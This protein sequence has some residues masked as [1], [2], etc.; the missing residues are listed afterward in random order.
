MNASRRTHAGPQ[1]RGSATI[2]S[3]ARDERDPERERVL[4]QRDAA[5]GQQEGVVE[6]V[7]EGEADGGGEHERLGKVE[8]GAGERAR[9]GRAAPVDGAA[10]CP[11]RS[12]EWC[13]G[14]RLPALADDEEA[15]LHVAERDRVAVAQRRLA[16]A[17]AVDVHA[18]EAAVVEQDDLAAR[19]R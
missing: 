15:H 7:E 8:C 13:R 1:R 12:L 3:D 10:R 14:V 2:A 17:L 6:G 16:D 5:A 18:V 4:G 9:R 19:G 11:P